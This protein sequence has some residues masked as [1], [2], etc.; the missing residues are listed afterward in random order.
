MLPYVLD[1]I[2]IALEN[3]KEKTEHSQVSFHMPLIPAFGRLRLI[4]PMFNVSLGYISSERAMFKVAV[5]RKHK[6]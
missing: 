4:H 5:S 2:Q 3:K 1:N 6:M